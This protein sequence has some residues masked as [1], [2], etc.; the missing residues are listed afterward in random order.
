MP[1]TYQLELLFEAP[2]ARASLVTLAPGQFV[3]AHRHGWCADFMFVVDGIL[4]VEFAEGQEE[5]AFERGQRCTVQPGVVHSTVN[6][7][8]RECRFLLVQIGCYDF[9]QVVG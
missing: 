9:Q 4:T 1:E 2:E 3:P 6:R 7:E 5:R 8:D